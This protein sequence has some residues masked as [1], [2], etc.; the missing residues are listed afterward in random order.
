VGTFKSSPTARKVISDIGNDPDP[1]HAITIN[2]DQNQPGVAFDRFAT[3]DVDLKDFDHLPVKPSAAHPK[4]VTR[5][6]LVVHFLSERRAA[7]LSPNPTVF[8]PRTTWVWRPRPSTA[9]TSVR[10]P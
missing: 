10:W 1:R 5:G 6:E 4:E 3:N 2:V 9:P 7:A 8:T